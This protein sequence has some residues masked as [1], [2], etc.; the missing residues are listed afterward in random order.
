MVGAPSH[1]VVVEKVRWHSMLSYRPVWRSKAAES[2]RRPAGVIGF[3]TGRGW[4]A[5][6]WS[7]STRTLLLYRVGMESSLLHA[8]SFGLLMIEISRQREESGLRAHF[9]GSFRTDLGGR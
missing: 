2:R 7:G 4:F 6:K 1:E 5:W 9:R 8:R 3:P